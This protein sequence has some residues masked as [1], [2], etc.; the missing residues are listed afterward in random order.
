[1][2]FALKKGELPKLPHI[3]QAKTYAAALMQYGGTIP[4]AEFFGG[5]G[6]GDNPYKTIPPLGDRLTAIRFAYF[7]RDD[8]RIEEFTIEPDPTWMGELERLIARLEKHRAN[9]TL[10][11]RLTD[12]QQDHWLCKSYCNFRTRCWNQDGEGVSPDA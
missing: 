5:D 1:M 6:W 9:G 3:K 10:P 8:L 12:R 11:P 4:N 7:S 2:E